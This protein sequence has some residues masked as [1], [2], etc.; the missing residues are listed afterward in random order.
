MGVGEVTGGPRP[1]G[2]LSGLLL[3]VLGRNSWGHG[4][5]LRPWLPFFIPPFGGMQA[6]RDPC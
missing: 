1:C 2:I 5:L 4:V 3:A 6:F